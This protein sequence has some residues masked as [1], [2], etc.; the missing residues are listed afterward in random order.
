MND[1]IKE[2]K[3]K[4]SKYKVGDKVNVLFDKNMT[5]KV[6]YPDIF[7]IAEVVYDHYLALPGTCMYVAKNDEKF[8][9]W[10]E[11]ELMLCTQEIEE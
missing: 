4:K 11:S 1:T 5:E 7:T 10:F 8:G 9:L 3:Y 6:L 2:P